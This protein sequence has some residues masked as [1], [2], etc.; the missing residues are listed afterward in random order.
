MTPNDKDFLIDF[1][2]FLENASLVR[3]LVGPITQVCAKWVAGYPEVARGIAEA[4]EHSSSTHIL[5]ALW[6]GIRM[7][8]GDKDLCLPR[9]VR[10]IGRMV[11][12][13]I[14]QEAN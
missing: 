14:E 10:E 7:H 6:A 9:E 1:S 12:K 13:M 11:Q 3:E 5:W 8:L 4:I 2:E